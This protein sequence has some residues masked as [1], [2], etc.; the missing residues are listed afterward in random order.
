MIFL[1]KGKWKMIINE[2]LNSLLQHA[3]FLTLK[4]GKVE[5]FHN[6]FF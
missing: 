4:Q 2:F 6:F 5:Q 3:L 1:N